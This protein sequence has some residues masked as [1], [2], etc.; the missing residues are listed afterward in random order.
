MAGVGV[1]GVV[2]ALWAPVAVSEVRWTRRHFPNLQVLHL[3]VFAAAVAG[4]VDVVLVVLGRGSP[5]TLGVVAALVALG[6]EALRRGLARSCDRCLAVTFPHADDAALDDATGCS[7]IVRFQRG[8]HVVAEGD[9]ADCFYI[10]TSGAAEVSR[11]NGEGDVLLDS[12]EGGGFFGEVGLL[13]SVPRT[14]T[15]RAVGELELLTLDRDGFQRLLERSPGVARD[16]TKVASQRSAPKEVR[17]DAIP[18]PPWTRRA[19]RALKHPSAMHYNRFVALVLGANVACAL[20]GAAV[21][22]WWASDGPDLSA[23]AVVAQVNFAFAIIFRQQY[24]INALAWLATRP[25]TSWPLRVRWLLGKYYHFGGLHVGGAIAGTLWY[26]VLVG[27]LLHEAAAGG[28]VS[29]A[30]VVVAVTIV[31]LFTVMVILALP[32]LRAA[33]HD[34]FEVTHR[35]CGWAALVLVWLNTL[36][37]VDSQRSDEPLGFALLSAPTFWLVLLTTVCAAWPWL[38][39]RRVPITVERPSSHAAII[40]LDHGVTPGIGTTRPISRNPVVGW[41]HFANVPAAPGTSGYRMVI[42]RA[43]D[44]TGRFLDD[45]PSHVWVRGIPTM[46]VANVRKLFRKVVLVATG[47][48]IGPMLGHLLDPSVPSRLVWVTKNPRRTYGDELIDEIEAAQPDAMI[49]DTDERGK[50][51]VLRLAYAAYLESGAEAV[52]CIANR[53]V[54]WM[55]VNGMERR[56]IP[57]FGPIWDS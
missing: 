35:F 32:R 50:P 2:V 11:L 34:R 56:G 44:W 47:S 30:N 24:V 48:G 19:Q 52:V 54:T 33:Q 25:P 20:I 6:A 22:G 31:T 14:A 45:P 17:E 40:K 29:N 12:Y 5:I 39:L 51:D 10:V 15:V 36:L 7:E 1:A 18:L 28:D 16:V 42:S 55:V 3:L 49:W 8:D 57:A 4:V 43:G 13:Q 41:H 9:A 23:I 38:L 37:F 53:T 46:G 26:F 21:A 27:S